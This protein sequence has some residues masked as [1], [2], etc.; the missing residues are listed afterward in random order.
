[1]SRKWFSIERESKDARITTLMAQVNDF[2]NQLDRQRQQLQ[3]D[4][5]NEQRQ[6]NQDHQNELLQLRLQLELEHERDLRQQDQQHHQER[7]Q[8]QRQHHEER[9]LLQRQHHQEQLQ[10][11]RSG[12]S[13]ISNTSRSSSS[14]TKDYWFTPRGD[15]SNVGGRWPT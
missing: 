14:C 3:R 6:K 15:G 1:V 8:Q 11:I 4:H 9:L 5:Q 13:S 7:L 12:C 2:P 10:H